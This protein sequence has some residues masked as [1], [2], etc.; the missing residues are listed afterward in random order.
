MQCIQRSHAELR[1]VTASEIGAKDESVFGQRGFTPKVGR[2][3]RTKLSLRALGLLR[4]HSSAKLMLPENVGPLGTMQW[5]E[6]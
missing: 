2:V 1:R 4:R 3:I 5:S 6:D